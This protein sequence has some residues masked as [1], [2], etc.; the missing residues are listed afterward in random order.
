MHHIASRETKTIDLV[1]PCP[2]LAFR[3]EFELLEG[4]SQLLQNERKPCDSLIYKRE[5]RIIVASTQ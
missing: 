1:V 5:T 4:L 3:R 2:N